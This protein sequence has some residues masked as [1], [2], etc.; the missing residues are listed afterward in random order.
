MMSQQARG[1]RMVPMEFWRGSTRAI[2]ENRDAREFLLSLKPG[3]VDLIVTSPPYFIGK[4]YDVS[5]SARDFVREVKRVLPAMLR[6]LRS[7]G[8]LCWQV[9][10]HVTAGQLVPLDV[11]VMQASARYKSLVLRN[12][13]IWTFGHGVHASSR[14]SGRH[15]TVMW[16]TKGSSYYFDLDSARV[17]QTYPGKRYY[18]GPRK[19]DWSG[20]PLGKN[21][22]DVWD[23]GDIW[24]IPN[25]KA[26]HVEKTA[27][28]CQ[29]PTAL[30]RRLVVALSPPSGF[31]VDPYVGSGSSAVAALLEER[32]F[33]GTDLEKKYLEICG[34]RLL[35]LAGGELKVREDLPVHQPSGREGVAQLPP[36]FAWGSGEEYAGDHRG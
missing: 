12:R 28:P 11:L 16:F 20:N 2:L 30:V 15:E 31:V 33:S 25:V 8:S 36:H 22:G 3:T 26:N 9:G 6:A 13:I 29:F 10:N 35:S 4:E 21:P 7:G 32:N 27:H 14:F 23:I 1:K 17:P 34:D 19:G 24:G 18:K 5:A